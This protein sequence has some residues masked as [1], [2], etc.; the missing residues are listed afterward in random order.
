MSRRACDFAVAAVALL[1][2]AVDHRPDESGALLDSRTLPVRAR[3]EPADLP[4]S[5]ES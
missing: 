2:F 1:T 3:L 4:Q 5:T